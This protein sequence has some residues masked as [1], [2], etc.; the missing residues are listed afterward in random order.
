MCHGILRELL[1][2]SI[3]LC[4]KEGKEPLPQSLTILIDT[5]VM[6]INGL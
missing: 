2:R 6:I 4:P 5:I 1:R 3:L